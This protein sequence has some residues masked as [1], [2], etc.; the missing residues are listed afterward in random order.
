M[1]R[2]ERLFEARYG[3][4]PQ[5]CEKLGGGG[6]RR[7][8]FRLK[9]NGCSAIGVLGTD[10]DENSAFIAIAR[11]FRKKGISVPEVYA[12]SPDAMAY[13]Q[14]D[15]GDTLLYSAVAPGRE[16]GEYSD[17]EQALLCRA[18]AELPKIQFEG[19]QGLD[20]S[21]CYPDSCFNARMVEFDL[22]YFKYC[23]L[24]PSGAEFNEVRLQDDF[25]RLKEDVLQDVGQTFMYRDF[26]ARNVMLR[27]SEP[28]FIDFQGGRRGPIFY[29]V[30]SFVWQARSRF[31]IALKE[32]LY[33]S[34]LE[35]LEPYLSI[36]HDEFIG[37]LRPFVLLRTLQV[38]GAY[39]FRGRIEGKSHFLDSIPYAIDN[40]RELLSQPFERYPYLTEVLLDLVKNESAETLPESQLEV[41][42]YSF[43]YKKGIPEDTSGNGGGYV[44]DCRGVHNPGRYERYRQSTGRDA[45]VRKFLEDD[46]EILDF[47]SHVYSIVDAHAEV[48][49]KRGFSHLQV[50][51][52]CTGG[53]H[54]SVYS[55]EALA[56]HLI[57]KYNI[58]VHL[59]HRELGIEKTLQR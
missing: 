11:H 8:Y 20:F 38:L 36:T 7:A 19:A 1:E 51:F 52:G 48:F 23:F 47:L 2:L 30:A 28:F 58:R 54:R 4:V 40:L 24:K 50:S 18:I 44:F 15:I 34:Y 46:G 39:G 12:A 16:R 26:Q 57:S 3:Q 13:L 17:E 33:S 35:A 43:S 45:D 9:G 25:D 49:I 22:N 5:S 41:T 55:A 53:Q 29:D 6:S 56:K 37:K 14:E 42:V 59:V 32:K 31:P 21:V 27:E 10:A